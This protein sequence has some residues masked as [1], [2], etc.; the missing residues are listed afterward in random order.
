MSVKDRPPSFQWFPRDFAAEMHQL[1]FTDEIEL[2]YRR[3]LDASWDSGNYGVGTMEE[4][5]KWG[6]V[7]PEL[8]EA[9]S[10]AIANVSQVQA[11]GS[12]VQMRMVR[13]RM[14]QAIRYKSN[15]LKGSKGGRKSKGGKRRKPTQAVL[16]QTQPQSFAFASASALE[17]SK[18]YPSGDGRVGG[19]PS[20]NGNPKTEWLEA[21]ERDFY[22]DYPRKVKPDDARKAWL[23]MRPWSQD[24]CDAIFSGLTRWKS[25]WDQHETPKDKIPY[26]ATFLRSGQ[27]KETP[28]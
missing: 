8:A 12:Y 11:N 18:P 1:G 24:N 3:A 4:W 6:R 17:E 26:P 16:K 5:L 19:S 13:D 9:Y 28:Q 23:Q 2:A 15:A 25:W 27:W 10:Q 22:P 14:E 21:F 7:R 20:A